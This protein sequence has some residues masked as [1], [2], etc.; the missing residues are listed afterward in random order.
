MKYKWFVGI[1]ISKETLDFTLY[2]PDDYKKSAHIELE[3]NKT[4]FKKIPVWLRKMQVCIKE[5]LFCM[6]HTGIYGLE[7]SIFMEDRDFAYSAVS[8]LEIK[9]SLGISRGKN[10]K[11]D[12]LKI[13]RYCYLHARE[14]KLSHL[15]SK[16]LRSLK[17]L[18]NERMRVVKMQTID[19]QTIREFEDISSKKS[20]KRSK[21]RL[22]AF[23][24][25]I[26]EIENEIETLINEDEGLKKNYNLVT[27][28][29]GIGLVNAVIFMVHSNNF[30]SFTN[31][32]KFACYGGVA[33]SR[34][35][36]A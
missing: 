20:V 15:P 30:H 1:D 14:L 31:G 28:V 16:K 24:E 3:N 11:I 13:S 18:L 23:K 19:K 17:L 4:G 5:T 6:E 34:Q 33:H 21:E 32:R 10:D 8:P 25:Q 36:I 9:H 12:S 35:A 7:L 27:S 26:Y 22:A 29:V 2:N